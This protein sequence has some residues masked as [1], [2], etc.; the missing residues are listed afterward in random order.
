MKNGWKL[1]LLRIFVLLAVLGLTVFLYLNGQFVRQFE[2]LGYPGIFLISLFSN[3]TLILPVPGV[4]FTSAMGAIFNPIWVALAAGTGAAIGEISGY[5]MGF[6]GQAVIENRTW[7][8]RITGWMKKY[9]D[10]IIFLLAVIPNPLFDIAGMVA[11]ALKLPLWR[12]LL[13]SWL[14][15]C[16]KMLAFAYGGAGLLQLFPFPA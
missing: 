11:G 16:I 5:L 10:V 1:N 2:A 6:S 13:W 7:Y 15:K 8:D 12:F 9:G 3:A 4:L 14:G